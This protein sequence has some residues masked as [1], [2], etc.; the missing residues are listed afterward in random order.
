VLESKF[1]I[2]R[3]RGRRRLGDR[4]AK[5]FNVVQIVAG[6]YPDEPPFDDRGKNEGG[7]PWEPGFTRINPAYFDA[8]DRKIQSLVRAELSSAIVGS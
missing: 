4:Q 1:S 5:R 6:L 8:A 3:G 2:W 7:F